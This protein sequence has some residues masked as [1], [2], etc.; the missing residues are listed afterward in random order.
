MSDYSFL[1]EYVREEIKEYL[2]SK[3]LFQKNETIENKQKM[4]SDYFN[5]YTSVKHC[6]VN[7]IISPVMMENIVAE[8][9]EY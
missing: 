5:A 6:V 2:K 7:G 8:L 3:E 4:F 9:K 1:P